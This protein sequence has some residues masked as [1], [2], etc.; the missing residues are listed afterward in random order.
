[1]A[2]VMECV[3]TSFLASIDEAAET[4]DVNLCDPRW[5][6]APQGWFSDEDEPE[7]EIKEIQTDF[8]RTGT[9][10]SLHH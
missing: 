5:R 1:M 7:P 2:K 3:S 10:L 6:V 4:R 9:T 8:G